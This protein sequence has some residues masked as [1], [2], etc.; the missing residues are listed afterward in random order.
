MLGQNNN[1]KV[2]LLN[3][4]FLHLNL[5]LFLRSTTGLLVRCPDNFY[6]SALLTYLCTYLFGVWLTYDA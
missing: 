1:G 5:H 4:S 2:T 6:G 3:Q